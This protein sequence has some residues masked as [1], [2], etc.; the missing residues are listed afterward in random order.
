MDRK[1]RR[2]LVISGAILVS[3]VLVGAVCFLLIAFGVPNTDAYRILVSSVLLSSGVVA[4]VAILSIVVQLWS[5][6]GAKYLQKRGI[7][8]PPKD[9]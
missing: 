2:R 7:L 8:T 5:Y 9:N 6:Q 1:L 4:L 3:A